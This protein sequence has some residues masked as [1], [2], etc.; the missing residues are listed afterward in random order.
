[1]TQT[2]RPRRRCF[3]ADSRDCS[4]PGALTCAGAAGP[5]AML[6]VLTTL[7]NTSELSQIT[8]AALLFTVGVAAAIYVA[9]STRKHG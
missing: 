3:S 8:V 5:L 6:I 9:V 7:S 1:M 4:T 2:R